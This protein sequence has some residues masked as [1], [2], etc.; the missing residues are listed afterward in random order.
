MENIKESVKNLFENK[1]HHDNVERFAQELYNTKFKDMKREPG[2]YHG[3]DKFEIISENVI[4]VFFTYGT[5][6][7]DYDYTSSFDVKI[8]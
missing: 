1:Y 3:Y 4:R 2:T 7:G 8:E 6:S 5:I